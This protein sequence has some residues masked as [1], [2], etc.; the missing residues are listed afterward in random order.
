MQPAILIL[1]VVSTWN[2]LATPLSQDSTYK[3]IRSQEV[4]VTALRQPEK[5][6]DVPLAVT[7]VPKHRFE[8]SRGFGLDEAL[9]LVSGVLVQSRTGNQDVRVMIR[10][11]GARGAGERS[12]AGTSRGIRFYI[13][14]IPETEPD[15]RTAFDLI[16]LSGATSIEVVRS[17]ASALWG[18]ASGGIVSINTIPDIEQPYISA[19]AYAGS[20][21]FFKQSVRAGTPT[22]I[23]KVY[24]SLNNTAFDGY[25]QQSRSALSQCYLGIVSNISSKTR[26]NTFLTAASNNFQIPGPLT[27]QQFANNPQ[28]AQ[29][30]P[31]IYNPTYVQRN[32]HRFN[33]LGRIGT[34][35]EH[36]FSNHTV[37]SAM[38]FLQSKYLQRSER[39]TFRD[40]HRYHTGG[41]LLL[42]HSMHLNDTLYA[43]IL[44]GSDIQYQDGA[45]LFY[46]QANGQRGTRLQTNKR[47]G[48]QNLGA[49]AQAECRIG[50]QVSITGGLR[51]D[52]ITYFND[53]FIN[54]KINESRAFERLT[55]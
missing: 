26:M 15:G 3:I 16:D 24:I 32:E 47:E 44:A 49:F 22:D 2:V 4:T 54:P 27:E 51:Y 5:A 11:F 23:G 19:Q 12:N 21:G 9:S 17:N 1:L 34:T 52:N 39:N 35:F 55:P 20:F 42:R 28:Q 36:A 31:T 37:L 46:N 8:Y 29:H 33:R 6:L 41:N 50:T 18:N 45:I 10:G 30:D 25:R 13:D 38:A 40:F 14:G 43:N 48:A 53:D 7:I